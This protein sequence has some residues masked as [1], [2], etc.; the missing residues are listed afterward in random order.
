M[1][2]AVLNY[3]PTLS[4]IGA[5]DITS[6][7]FG[8]TM[9]GVICDPN[10][11]SLGN[12]LMFEYKLIE[13]NVNVPSPENVNLGFVSIENA[14]NS[15]ISNKWTISIP[16]LDDRYDPTS[17]VKISIRLYVGLTGS[18][19]VGV[20]EWSAQL[21]V[22]NPPSQPLIVNAYYD[23]PSIDNDDLFIFLNEDPNINYNVVKFVAA[24][25]YQDNSETTVWGVSVP[26]QAVLVTTPGK[27]ESKYM[28]HVAEFGTVSLI[29]QKIYA[30]VYAVYE[31]NDDANKF[32]SVSHISNTFHTNLASEY[33]APEVTSI[34]YSVY[35]DPDTQIMTV[36]WNEPD[37]AR[38]PTYNVNYY[39][40][41]LSIDNVDWTSVTNNIPN[42]TFSYD[43]NVASYNCNTTLYFRVDAV[44]NFGT[45]SPPSQSTINSQLNIYK[46]ANQP[47]N[48]EI[49]N[50]SYIN[51]SGLVTMN[52][53][54][55][56]PTYNGC[57]DPIKFAVI[58]NGSDDV[59][60]TSYVDYVDTIDSYTLYFS[61]NNVTQS[62]NVE[63]YLI[64][65]DT[66]QIV[67][68]ET[69]YRK[70]RSEFTPYIVI[71]VIL[72]P[73][74]YNVYNSPYTSQNMILNWENPLEEMVGGWSI[75]Q[76][77]VFYKVVGNVIG[78]WTSLKI[79][80]DNSISHTYDASNIPDNNTL[81]FK[82]EATLENSG[83]I[84][85]FTSNTQNINMF[86]FSNTPQNVKVLWASED[87][88]RTFI[89]IK[90]IFSNPT[91]T[92]G[93]EV[94]NFVVNIN[95]ANGDT[96]QQRNITYI[97][98]QTTP[99]IVNFNN[100]PYISNGN[101]SINM[102]NVD[103]NGR[104]NLNG[105]IA[106]QPFIADNLPIFTDVYMNDDRNE[107][108]INIVTQTT[109]SK[110][111][112]LLYVTPGNSVKYNVLQL[113]TR[114]YFKIVE[115]ILTNGEF[116]YSVTMFP[117]LFGATQ[118]VFPSQFSLAVSNQVGIQTIDGGIPIIV[119]E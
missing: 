65:T 103:T 59:S 31:F 35:N 81:S 2:S 9:Y 17:K 26:L 23:K 102:V 96:K 105:F 13:E 90:M 98:E 18:A 100:I 115:T 41:Y 116:N 42:D 87:T 29:T 86:R 12:V 104:G 84:C 40:L 82:I 101:I 6:A 21:N 91:Y 1:S 80:T 70:G 14:V 79:I 44:S 108:K 36:N 52:I 43:V 54:F 33:A 3:I 114:T 48:I 119:E 111:A 32:Y 61:S 19:E 45:I 30:A 72:E 25:Y 34:G 62:G 4:Y 22:H 112:I 56:K 88:D 8:S 57:G 117:G 77:E 71:N 28:I 94:V 113:V 53:N 99:Y 46:I 15:G 63:V 106:S 27:Y 73:V 93:G 24:Y 69:N 109:L 74:D 58:V 47:L 92:G 20:T 16:S 66:N 83:V 97:Q 118:T 64:T 38:I 51:E 37:N 95:D 39:R 78:E 55:D 49:S 67:F 89:D 107:Y 10:I 110:S 11:V 5:V 75:T 76:Y 60:L 85:Q 50:M 68:G 7:Q